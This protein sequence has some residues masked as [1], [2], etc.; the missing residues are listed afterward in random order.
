MFLR[1]K[2]GT[3]DAPVMEDA[4]PPHIDKTQETLDTLADL[5][6]TGQPAAASPSAAPNGTD[7]DTVPT[8][9]PGVIKSH[10]NKPHTSAHNHPVSQ[11]TAAAKSFF[12]NQPAS[13]IKLRP[14]PMHS[15]PPGT[16]EVTGV[17]GNLEPSSPIP[18]SPEPSSKQPFTTTPGLVL[19]P[20]AAATID[21][22]PAAEIEHAATT[23]PS[24]QFIQP[25]PVHPQPIQQEPVG[26][27]HIEAVL[28]GNLPGLAGPWATQYAQAVADSTQDRVL[29]IHADN[30]STALELIQPVSQK[31]LQE[32]IELPRQ[33][34][35]VRPFVRK[36]LTHPV[37][38]IDRVLVR[39][40][41][42][43][44]AEQTERLVTLNSW[45]WLSGPDDLSIAAAQQTLAGLSQG[46]G[47][48]S[49]KRHLQLVIAGCDSD[50]ARPAA[51]RI[52][53]AMA[54]VAGYHVVQPTGCIPK[55]SPAR[56]QPLGTFPSQ[57]CG[58]SALITDLAGLSTAP[59]NFRPVLLPTPGRGQAAERMPAAEQILE[60]TTDPL[61]G[62]S[63][64]SGGSPFE[65]P[66]EYTRNQNFRVPPQ[67]RPTTSAP[68]KE[69]GSDP[70]LGI[71]ADR[72]PRIITPPHRTRPIYTTQ[73]APPTTAA[74]QPL[75][76]QTLGHE[77]S[78]AG[79]APEL[80]STSTPSATQARASIE[81][82]PNL[83]ALLT[84]DDCALAGAIRLDA[85]CP[86]HEEVQLVLDQNGCLHLLAKHEEGTDPGILRDA[87][88]DLMAA[89]TWV[90]EHRN[91]IA[92][93]QRQ[94][95]FDPDVEPQ[96]HLFTPR[97]DW[98]TGLI[99]R[100]GNA[101]R[102][103]LLAKVNVGAQATWFT[104]AL[105]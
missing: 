95:K 61:P 12:T 38:P 86:K 20:Q 41:P 59:E 90:N 15:G 58:L 45:T 62:G 85:R 42:T 27:A 73:A 79:P 104:T 35:D 64:G 53:Q 33:P 28:L 39:M 11:N 9:E 4:L 18:S 99:T 93:T 67:P 54:P 32:S 1:A 19:S 71:E 80:P 34:A 56:I 40:E 24:Q 91:L 7:A 102:L 77:P 72:D 66:I 88:L 70:F 13:P 16:D 101:L 96:L 105:N 6:L 22:L 94:L 57:A 98:A 89:R 49:T 23:N 43:S 8:P 47:E 81:D 60:Q 82:A 100:L 51:S 76:P 29:L 68:T 65:Q 37:Q 36:L 26:T 92:L 63:E 97:A 75:D 21:Q 5:F 10:T 52:A 3:M 17:L 44:T 74:P 2:Q 69:K 83:T 30:H 55:M 46:F 25:E 50:S 103:H 78:H 84:A 14:K 87:M 48:Q 31:P